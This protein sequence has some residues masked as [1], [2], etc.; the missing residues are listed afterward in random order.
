MRRTILGDLRSFLTLPMAIL[1]LLALATGSA[2]AQ[3][4]QYVGAKKCKS[5]HEKEEMGNQYDWW[6]LSA[7]GKAFETLATDKAK[8]WAAEKGLGDPQQSD[9]C[10]KCHATAHGVPD[11]GV[12][13]KFVRTAGVQCESCHGAG[14]DYR[15]KKIMIDRDL[16]ISKGLVPQSEKVCVTCHNDESPAWNLERYTRAD[17]S[18]VGFDYEQALKEIAHPVPEGYDPMADEPE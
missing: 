7:H 15:K 1:L 3:D 5:C 11:E 10:V 9:E 14:K 4:H 18:K 2:R 17:G 16:A 13:R 6:M 12:S 8:K